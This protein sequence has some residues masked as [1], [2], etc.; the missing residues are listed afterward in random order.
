MRS[1]ILASLIGVA[2]CGTMEERDMWLQ[3]EWE[4]ACISDAAFT[5]S[6]KSSLSIDGDKYEAKKEIFYGKKCS[7]LLRVDREVMVITAVTK[8][9]AYEYGTISLR[10]IGR[11][12]VA[13]MD[14]GAVEGANGMANYGFSDWKQGVYHTVLYPLAPSHRESGK[15]LISNKLLI[16]G[17]KSYT[18]K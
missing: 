2:G 14:K 7:H 11:V 5:T 10:H 18:R 17:D 1:L 3:G 16:I 6:E 9:V 15:F 13:M 12:D 8:P 4:G